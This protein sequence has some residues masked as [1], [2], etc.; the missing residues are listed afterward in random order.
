VNQIG[1]HE[2]VGDSRLGTNLVYSMRIWVNPDKMAKLGITASDISSAIQSQNRQNPAGAFG[3]P[4]AQAGTDF[5]YSVTT[6]PAVWWSRNNS[7]DIVH[8][9]AARCIAAAPKRRRLA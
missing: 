5:Q 3:Q 8:A 6:R 4:P 7:S 2:G 9:R 1:K